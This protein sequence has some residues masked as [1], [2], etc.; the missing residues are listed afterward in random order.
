MALH[1]SLFY[2]FVSFRILSQYRIIGYLGYLKGAL[3]QTRH[4]SVDEST[5]R[6]PGLLMQ[7]GSRGLGSFLLL[8]GSIFMD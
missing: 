1:S 2:N 5:P 7:E 6:L 4:A 8:L 3:L